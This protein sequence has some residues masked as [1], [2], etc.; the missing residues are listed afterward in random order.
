LDRDENKIGGEQR[1]AHQG[2]HARRAIDDDVIGSAGKFW[3]FAM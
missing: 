3:R 1:R 2:G